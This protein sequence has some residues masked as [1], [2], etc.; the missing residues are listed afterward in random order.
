M[1]STAAIFDMGAVGLGGVGLSDAAY[2]AMN[3]IV[4]SKRETLDAIENRIENA[5]FLTGDGRLH[6]PFQVD[7]QAASRAGTLQ[8]P[9][10]SQAHVFEAGSRLGRLIC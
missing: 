1:G 4:A 2:L 9:I 8:V 5:Y 7:K 3:K 6:C 10:Q